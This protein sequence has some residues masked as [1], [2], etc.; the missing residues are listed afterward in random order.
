MRKRLPTMIGK[1]NDA[2]DLFFLLLAH[3]EGLNKGQISLYFWPDASPSEIKFRL[4]NTIYRM[5]HA[6]GKEAVV[7]QEEYYTFNHTLDYEYDL[8]NFQKEIVL[9]RK[10]NNPE[11]VTAHLIKAV[12]FYKGPFLPDIE[13]SWIISAREHLHQNYLEILMKLAEIFLTEKDFSQALHYSQLAITAD[14]CFESAYRMSMRIHAAEGNRA[15]VVRQFER[16]K[17]VLMKEIEVDPS[18]QTYELYLTLT[19]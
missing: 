14:P 6:V 13:D 7:L 3:P 16:C 18:P 8:E 9:A 2:R 11:R 5:R 1:T 17:D 12:K 4:K 10:A 19:R 15:A